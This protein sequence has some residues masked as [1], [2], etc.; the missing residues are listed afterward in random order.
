M[1]IDLSEEQKLMARSAREFVKRNVPKTLVREMEKDDRGFTPE[2]WKEMADLGWQ[3]CVIP[4][5]YGGVGGSFGD[6]AVLLEEMGRACLPGPFFSTV[7]LGAMLLLE[8]GTE[9]QKIEILPR[10]ADGEAI[11]T[12]ALTEAGATWDA[13][14]VMT[15]AAPA[16][17]GYIIS[18]TKLFVPDAH[19]A[20]WII[21]VARTSE[22]TRPEEGITLFL[23][24]ARTLGISYSVLKT[25]APGK[26]CEVVFDKVKVSRGS[27]IGKENKGWKVVEMVLQ[28]AAA[29]KCAEMTGGAQEVLEMAIKYANERIQFGHPIGSFQAVQHHCANMAI[30]VDGMIM[31]T[32]QAVWML[33][34]RIPCRKEVSIAK[35][36][37]S[38]AFKRCTSLGL[39]IHGG[40]GFMEDSDIAL[41]YRKARTDEYLYGDADFHRD[42][43]SRELRLDAP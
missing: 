35:A 1:N 20:D 32:Q 19:V 16:G 24:N 5:E 34:E 31:T 40:A 36:W 39:R 30:D 27:I 18:G 9:S 21:C 33:S 11:L 10:V 28:W 23:V 38:D 7:V 4:K 15:R 22:G 2:T 12:M 8:A 29:G 41:F 13:A 6:L 43:V 26:Q 3:G 25:I 14:G 37:S 42:V 17:D